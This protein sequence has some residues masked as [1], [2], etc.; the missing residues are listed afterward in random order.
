[1]KNGIC[2]KCQA[3]NVHVAPGNRHEVSVPRKG[4]SSVKAF[5]ELYFCGDCGYIEFYVELK[6]DLAKSAADWPKVSVKK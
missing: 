4:V 2:P 3:E 5:A 1:M 6:E